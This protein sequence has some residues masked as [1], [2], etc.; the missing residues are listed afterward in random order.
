MPASPAHLGWVLDVTQTLSK[1]HSFSCLF[2]GYTC[3]PEAQYPTQLGQ[4]AEALQYL[5]EKEGKK[6]SDVSRISACLPRSCTDA[7]QDHNWW[8]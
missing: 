8:R 2:L 7:A 5:L 1:E 6:P 3:A 4:A